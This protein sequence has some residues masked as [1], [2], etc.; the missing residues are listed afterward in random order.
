LDREH[1]TTVGLL[2]TVIFGD[3]GRTG[4]EL[5]QLV[6]FHLMP[7]H[8]SDI[9]KCVAICNIYY[10]ESSERLSN[11]SKTHDLERRMY[12]MLKSFISH[13]CWTLS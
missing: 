10:Y 11:D 12:I 5:L 1:Q 2:M 9:L 4:V 7:H 3:F 6:I 13:I 8:L